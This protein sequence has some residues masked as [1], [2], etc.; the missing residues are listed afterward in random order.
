MRNFVKLLAWICCKL[1]NMPVES[2]N[3][4]Y[5]QHVKQLER[6]WTSR[7]P[8]TLKDP[9]VKTGLYPAGLNWLTYLERY[10]TWRNRANVSK[11]KHA[12]RPVLLFFNIILLECLI[13]H[14]LKCFSFSV[15][16]TTSLP[17]SN[18]LWINS[19]Y[20][21]TVGKGICVTLSIW[22]EIFQPTKPMN[23][24]RSLWDVIMISR[25]T[26]KLLQ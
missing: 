5:V 20:K 3:W 1:Q 6:G 14:T 7:L 26:S 12:F 24:N 4:K 10:L 2:T 19:V 23:K 25:R 21:Q 18:A 13:L 17:Y 11:V 8:E 9:W 16:V 15:L 22:F